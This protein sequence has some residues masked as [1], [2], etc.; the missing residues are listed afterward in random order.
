MSRFFADSNVVGYAFVEERRNAVATRILENR[1]VIS[2]QVLNEFTNIARKKFR[3][4]W[5]QIDLA[6]ARIC[7][8]SDEIVPLTVALHD[9]GRR[10]STQ[11]RLSVYDG[12]IVAAALSAGCDILYTED[13]HDGLVIENSLKIHNPFAGD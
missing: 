1:P 9:D 8:I 6:I 7:R 11:Y 13:M 10:L 4:E 3:F 12:F 5:L 2:V